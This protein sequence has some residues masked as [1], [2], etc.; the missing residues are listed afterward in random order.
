LDVESEQ[1]YRGF[2]DDCHGSGWR[3]PVVV[4]GWLSV[5]EERLL[6]EIRDVSMR[7]VR[8]GSD[9]WMGDAERVEDGLEVA[10]YVLR[11]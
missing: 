1:G 3:R 2:W 6:G 11:G 9:V 10:G 5:F 7:L 8:Y 4:G